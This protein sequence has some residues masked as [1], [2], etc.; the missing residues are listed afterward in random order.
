[1]VQSSGEALKNDTVAVAINHLPGVPERVVVFLAVVDR[2]DKSLAMIVH[3]LA[4]K[5]S[6]V[7]LPGGARIVIGFVHRLVPARWIVVR[8]DKT[9][10]KVARAFAIENLAPQAFAPG[11]RRRRRPGAE[12]GAESDQALGH[13]ESTARR[14]GERRIAARCQTLQHV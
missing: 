10:R 7:E 3:R 5:N 9:A 13:P 11:G 2:R 6:T 4:A 14:L 12:L 8:A 1:H